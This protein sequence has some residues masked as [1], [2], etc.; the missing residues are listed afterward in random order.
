MDIEITSTEK[1]PVIGM[2]RRVENSEIGD[3]IR[4]AFGTVGPYFNSHG[5]EM[6]GPPVAIF[7]GP[8]DGK[9]DVGVGSPVVQV[10]STTDEMIE[11]ELAA[12]KVATAVYTG[13]YE[14]VSAAWEELMKELQ[15]RGVETVE[16]CWEEYITDPSN[17]PDSSKWQT[18]LVQPLA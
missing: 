11:L 9:S 10:T 8:V 12:G 15:A 1:R 2:R 4:E 7:Y 3:F 5:M 6:T 17:E 14:G 16:P 18:L 13:P